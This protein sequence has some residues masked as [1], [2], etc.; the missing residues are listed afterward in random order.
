MVVP[1]EVVPVVSL[2]EEGSAAAAG[3]WTVAA[4]PT[5]VVVAMTFTGTLAEAVPAAAAGDE[6]S[7]GSELDEAEESVLDDVEV[8]L[9]VD[10]LPALT[11]PPLVERLTF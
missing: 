11:V 1:V 5:V 8:E 2:L 9:L 6:D 4:A 10:A 3:V 7:E